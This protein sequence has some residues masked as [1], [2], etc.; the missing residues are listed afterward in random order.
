AA[1]WSDLAT[2]MRPL[3]SLQL[4][5]ALE[6]RQGSYGRLARWEAALRALY[7]GIP[8]YRPG[9][10]A[11]TGGDGAPLELGHS[12]TLGDSDDDMAAFLAAAGYMHVRAVLD[13]Q[14]VAALAAEARRVEDVVDPGDPHTWWAERPDGERVLCRVIYLQ[15]LSPAMAALADAA[16]LARLASLL[17]T[18][19]LSM[20][21]RMDGPTLLLKPAGELRGLANLPWHQDCGLGGHP[22]MC[23]SLS[24]GVQIT[25]ST[26]DTGCF[27]V[28]AGSHGQ[29]VPSTIGE[30]TLADWPRVA[31]PTSPGDVTVHVTDV[32]HASP[33]PAGG[34]GRK[35]LYLSYYQPALAEHI[36]PGEAVND[37]IRGRQADAD[38]I[39]SGAAAPP[40]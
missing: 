26:P 36:G 6:L 19:V 28:V 14:E 27:E 3:V 5:G 24:I 30:D 32:L 10:A 11:L 15:R 8:P 16:R 34:G 31:V 21:D 35:T 7:L 9:R 39:R 22:V 29:S 38:A 40:R 20:P 1:S 13:P 25:G 4:A 23:P 33:A 37:L 18:P 2:S 17:G 12:F